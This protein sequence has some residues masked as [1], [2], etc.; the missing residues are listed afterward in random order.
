MNDKLNEFEINKIFGSVSKFYEKIAIILYK[1]ITQELPIWLSREKEYAQDFIPF[2]M[3]FGLL[4]TGMEKLNDPTNKKRQ[5]LDSLYHDISLNDMTVESSYRYT[6]EGIGRDA[7]IYDK[8]TLFIE[9]IREVA[10]GL[11]ISNLSTTEEKKYLI[12]KF[13]CNNDD[14]LFT[15]FSVFLTKFYSLINISEIQRKV[16]KT[17]SYLRYLL[18]NFNPDIKQERFNFIELLSIKMRELIPQEHKDRIKIFIKIVE[19]LSDNQLQKLFKWFSG[20]N[21]SPNVIS[22]H[23]IPDYNARFAK[24]LF[25]AHLCSNG[26]DIPLYNFDDPLDDNKIQTGTSISYEEKQ[27]LIKNKLKQILLNILETDI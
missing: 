11:V 22:I 20:L 17:P 10:E 21:Y 27:V 24:G 16:L 26:I 8:D 5:L 9:H 15:H 1:Y 18:S 6:L 14:E 23:F 13:I 2:G 12:K 7:K 4:L 25:K 19:E 3:F